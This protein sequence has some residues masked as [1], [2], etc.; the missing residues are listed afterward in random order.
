MQ[1]KWMVTAA[2]LLLT[3]GQ[4]AY[5]QHQS[6]TSFRGAYRGPLT[7]ADGQPQQYQQRSS[8]RPFDFYG[9]SDSQSASTPRRPAYTAANVPP[10]HLNTDGTITYYGSDSSLP[11]PSLATQPGQ[12]GTGSAPQ[13]QQQTFQPPA[14]TM[15]LGS[16]PGGAVVSGAAPAVGCPCGVPAVNQFYR[17]VVPI[18]SV[19]ARFEVGRGIYGQ[20]KLYVPN[21]P[22]RNFFRYLTP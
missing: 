15:P 1:I 4:C 11:P 21:Q 7:T 22:V 3:A 20:P 8:F 9:A 18:E 5:A 13:I 19:P 6:A 2:V 14:V 10:A 16:V 12:T 17:P